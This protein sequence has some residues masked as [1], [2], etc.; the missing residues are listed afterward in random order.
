MGYSP[1]VD[2]AAGSIVIPKNDGELRVGI[3]IK[4]CVCTRHTVTDNQWAF[5]ERVKITYN[6]W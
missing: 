1:Q 6:N 3:C 2:L 4:P 5:V